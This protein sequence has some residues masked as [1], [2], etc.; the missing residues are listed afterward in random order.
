MNRRR[1]LY[2]FLLSLFAAPAFAQDEPTVVFATPEQIRA[3]F[4]VEVEGVPGFV[5][6]ENDAAP[7]QSFDISLPGIENPLRV[8]VVSPA[9]GREQTIVLPIQI[10]DKSLARGV[11]I[12]LITPEGRAVDLKI[13]PKRV[14]LSIPFNIPVTEEV[15]PDFGRSN[16]HLI[17]QIVPRITKKAQVDVDNSATEGLVVD[18]KYEGIAYLKLKDT[19]NRTNRRDMDGTFFFGRNKDY[20]WHLIT[21]NLFEKFDERNVAVMKNQRLGGELTSQWRLDRLNNL[22]RTRFGA[23]FVYNEDKTMV[24]FGNIDRQVQDRIHSEIGYGS[25]RLRFLARFEGL[26]VVNP[27]TRSPFALRVDRCG[28]QVQISGGDDRTYYYARVGNLKVQDYNDEGE[29]DDYFNLQAVVS[30]RLGEQMRG[31]RPRRWTVSGEASAIVWARGSNSW[32]EGDLTV[33][34]GYKQD[35]LTYFRYN[36][37]YFTITGRPGQPLWESFFI[38]FMRNRNY[39]NRSDRLARWGLESIHVDFDYSR[40]GQ[41]ESYERKIRF[42]V[43]KYITVRRYDFPLEFYFETVRSHVFRPGLTISIRRYL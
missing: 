43:S 5:R 27:S 16:R 29:I 15:H 8:A 28:Y 9:D 12:K 40:E 6:M 39:F 23:N 11:T 41:G 38:S 10:E 3:G 22:N 31:W 34:V 18:V 35:Y 1:I 24:L 37:D 36:N 32:V 17:I 30:R 14:F 21:E 20:R 4:A 2:V 26:E 42:G 33:D 7:G 25:D 13:P 19:L